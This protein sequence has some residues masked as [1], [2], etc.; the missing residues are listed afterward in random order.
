M[1]RRLVMKGTLSLLHRSVCLVKDGLNRHEIELHAIL[2]FGVGSLLKEHKAYLGVSVRRAS[3][4]SAEFYS[5]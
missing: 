5:L 3:V 2:T 1:P 4:N